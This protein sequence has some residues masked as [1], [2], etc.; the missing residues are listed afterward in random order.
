[1][2][3][4]NGEV[5]RRTLLF[6]KQEFVEK[7]RLI[8][9]NNGFQPKFWAF[10]AC[11]PPDQFHIFSIEPHRDIESF[12]NKILALVLPEK[13]NRRLLIGSPPQRQALEDLCRRRGLP[14]V[15]LAGSDEIIMLCIISGMIPQAGLEIIQRGVRENG[16]TV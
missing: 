4:E 7:F 5:S 10:A 9:V 13:V 2:T 16:K 1:M 3:L 11:F 6:M 8:G 12:R 15:V 14:S